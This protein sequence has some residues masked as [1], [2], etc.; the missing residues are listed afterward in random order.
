MSCPGVWALE[1]AT[2]RELASV[3]GQACPDSNCT[4]PDY[5]C[6]AASGST[7]PP[8]GADD[9][10]G[11][12]IIKVDEKI[13]ERVGGSTTTSWNMKQPCKQCNCYEFLWVFCLVDYSSCS[14]YG[15]EVASCVQ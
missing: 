1:L 13:S 4:E 5:D 14:D 15:G 2:D 7:C 3:V 11:Y 10:L 6:P 8:A 9:C 12:P